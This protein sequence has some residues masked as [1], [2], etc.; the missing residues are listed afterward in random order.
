M[1]QTEL[2]SQLN[3]L[4]EADLVNPSTEEDAEFVFK[5]A[6][7]QDA[8]YKLLLRR[9]R[10]RL[11]REVAQVLEHMYADQLDEYASLL[12][13][14][15]GEAG[16]KVKTYEYALRAGDVAARLHAYP[17][18]REQYSRAMALLPSKMETKDEKRERVDAVIRQVSV[19]L[20]ADDLNQQSQRLN[21]AQELLDSFDMEAQDRVRHARIHYWLGRVYSFQNNLRQAIQSF[22]YVLDVANDLDD[23]EMLALP[24]GVIGR[25]LVL[26]GHWSKGE[27][28]LR[29]AMEPLK[30]A[31]K[32][33]DYVLAVAFIGMAQ[34][35]RGNYRAGRDS[36]LEAL[37]QAEAIE[38]PTAVN[39][40]RVAYGYILLNGGEL[41][42]AVEHA[43]TAERAASKMQDHAWVYVAHGLAAWG[44]GRMGKYS[45][46]MEEFAKQEP[47]PA[48]LGGS[49]VLSDWFAA[50]RAEITLAMGEVDCAL[51]L[52][53]S[54][55]NLARKIG[56]VYAEGLALRVLGQALTRLNLPRRREAEKELLNSLAAFE[57]ENANVEAARTRLALARFYLDSGR[58]EQAREQLQFAKEQLSAGNFESDLKDV[59]ALLDSLP[60][61]RR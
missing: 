61:G 33:Y 35:A 56:G 26:Q 54:A 34:M 1:N 37:K 19:S 29:Q 39:V 14:H 50:A 25:A 3:E 20:F 9:D 57:R 51:E 27:P 6:L 40:S 46:A 12:A 60:T 38:H 2:V 24:A 31:G 32:M 44:L 7:V 30:R 47:Y 36:V 42:L 22:Q 21:Q 13:R 5:H 17:E 45:E 48:K 28:L 52:A 15:Y 53:Q 41:E 49:I 43:R 8:A 11:H 18:A 59:R 16:D 23:P 58:P 10:R 4:E 55:L